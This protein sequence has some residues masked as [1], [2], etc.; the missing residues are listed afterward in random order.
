MKLAVLLL[1]LCLLTAATFTFPQRPE[2]SG[3]RLLQTSE[4]YAEWVHEETIDNI[5]FGTPTRVRK[6]SSTILTA[7]KVNRRYMDVTADY[8]A[9]QRVHTTV[10]PR[11]KTIPNYPTPNPASHPEVLSI[12]KQS[13]PSKLKE[14]VRQ[15]TEIPTR[16]YK[17]SQASRASA[18]IREQ[19]EGIISTSKIPGIVVD[20]IDN[21][22]Y[23][24]ANVRVVIPATSGSANSDEVVI[25]GAHLDSICAENG[26]SGGADGRSPGADDDAS[27]SAT[28]LEVLRLLVDNQWQGSRPIHLM[29]FA[30]EEPGL[31]GS[32]TV[33]KMYK[34]AGVNVHGMLQFDMSGY[35][36]KGV[37]ITTLT[38]PNK[39]MANYLATLSLAYAPDVPM[40]K[41]SCGY[42]CSDQWSFDKQ[43][44]PAGMFIEAEPTD[45]YIHSPKDTMDRLDF[46]GMAIFAQLGVAFA[47]EIAR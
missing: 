12:L 5:N 30:A 28:V 40:V 11:A 9:G 17:S 39:K 34:N 24:Q 42:A 14:I 13:S 21:S 47:T 8:E 37:V 23:K 6:A 15:M 10:D 3:W 27:G 36:S 31:L 18:F 20:Y 41:D 29:W 32:A 26:C 1:S 38:D 19:V 4:Y 35:L 16:Y 22:G 43:G 7:I 44:Y 45:P 2:G 33:A 25:V 46:D